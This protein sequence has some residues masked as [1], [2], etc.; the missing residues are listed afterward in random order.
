MINWLLDLD[1]LNFKI[2]QEYIGNIEKFLIKEDLNY[3]SAFV[4]ESSCI[5]NNQIN[6]YYFWSKIFIWYAYY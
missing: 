2:Q 1:N 3:L 4:K 6:Q 5:S